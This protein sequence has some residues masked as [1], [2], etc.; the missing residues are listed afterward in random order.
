MV[1]QSTLRYLYLQQ[2]NLLLCVLLRDLPTL[3]QAHP[4]EIRFSYIHSEEEL[5]LL[6]ENQINLYVFYEECMTKSLEE[7]KRLN[8]D[9]NFT[10]FCK[11]ITVS[12]LLWIKKNFNPKGFYSLNDLDLK[13]LIQII[14]LDPKLSFYS[15]S[16][17]GKIE[18]GNR[19]KSLDFKLLEQLAAGTKAMELHQHLPASKSVIFRRKKRLKRLLNVEGKSDTALVARAIRLGYL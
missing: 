1:H 16:I 19:L 9:T 15:Q 17:V 5:L 7:F 11:T 2:G 13:Q 3:D 12:T 18:E 6:K 10:F 4:K 8:P 14:L